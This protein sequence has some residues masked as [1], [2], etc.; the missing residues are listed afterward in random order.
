MTDIDQRVRQAFA[1]DEVG[2]A[3]EHLWE[4]VNASLATT[5]HLPRRKNRPARLLLVTIAACLVIAGA[6]LAEPAV[7]KLFGTSPEDPANKMEV[8]QKPRATSTPGLAIFDSP[9]GAD[10]GVDA[11]RRSMLLSSVEAYSAT[12]EAMPV[13]YMRSL[14]HIK[15]GAFEYEIVAV[16]TEEGRVCWADFGPSGGGSSCVPGFDE[17]LPIRGGWGITGR[18]DDRYAFA[19]GLAADG[20]K[21]VRVVLEGGAV[22]D[23]TMGQNAYFW[24]GPSD[25]RIRSLA[26]EMQGGKVLTLPPAPPTTDAKSRNP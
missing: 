10:D 18:P 11:N 8:F 1:T 12:D 24:R 4:R 15:E 20:V 14:L 5:A 19:A 9:A 17:S 22:H 21:H 6:A 13:S 2:P 23:A 3:N 26:V 25:S 7:L 16:P